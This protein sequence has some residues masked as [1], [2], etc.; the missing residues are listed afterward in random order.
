MISPTNK[1]TAGNNVQRTRA[2]KNRQSESALSQKS[3]QQPD[4]LQSIVQALQA[5][6]SDNEK[7]ALL[8]QLITTVISSSLG[9]KIVSEPEYKQMHSWVSNRLRNSDDAQMLFKSIINK[10]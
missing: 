8:N 7:A 1:I 10:A 6:N 4:A 2:D 9:N 3:S 5:A